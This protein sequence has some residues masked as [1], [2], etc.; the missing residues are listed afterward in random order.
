MKGKM[1][2]NK[3]E[4]A[5]TSAIEHTESAPVDM[6]AY[7]IQQGA[8]VETEGCFDQMT[9]EDKREANEL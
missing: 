3:I 9:E 1:M 6:I 2:E 4:K 5:Q 8:S 7:A